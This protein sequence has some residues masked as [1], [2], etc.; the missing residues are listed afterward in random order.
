MADYVIKKNDYVEDNVVRHEVVQRLID[1][2]LERGGF[3]S[4]I[5]INGHCRFKGLQRHI[6]YNHDEIWH[7]YEPCP[8][9][10]DNKVEV[11]QCEMEEFARVWVAKGY[12]ISRGID[13][14]WGRV[15]YVFG[16]RPFT[17]YGFKVVTEFSDRL[18][19]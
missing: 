19:N 9:W 18:N 15:Q 11:K 7:S 1:Y 5:S 3:S 6:D 2:F 4:K 12:F 16:A 17:D 10:F 14:K 13:D 8:S